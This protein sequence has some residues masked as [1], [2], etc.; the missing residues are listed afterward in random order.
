MAR[1]AEKEAMERA[2]AVALQPQRGWKIVCSFEV[3]TRAQ[4]F[5]ARPDGKALAGQSNKWFWL[6][7][8]IR[9]QGLDREKRRG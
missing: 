2:R 8:A 7:L 3:K 6:D 1:V 9:S 5:Y 4:A